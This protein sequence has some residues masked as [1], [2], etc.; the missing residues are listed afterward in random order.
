MRE[1]SARRSLIAYVAAFLT[2]L[3]IGPRAFAAQNEC[4]LSF[5]G[6]PDAATNG[7]AVTCDDCNAACDTDG[8]N[9]PNKSCTF[10]IAVCANE[11]GNGCTAADIKK[12]MV[13]KSGG[14]CKVKGL[15]PT[16][17]GT[18]SVCGAFTAIVVKEK[19]NGKKPGKCKITISAKSKSKPHQQDKDVL[20]LTCT[21]QTASSC[22]TTTSTTTVSSTTTTTMAVC[23]DGIKNGTEQCDDGN[24]VED[25]GCDSNCTIPA[26]GNGILDAS[27]GEACDPPCGAGCSAGQICNSQCQCVAAAACACGTQDP[28]TL[29]FT[30]MVGSGNCG[31]IQDSTGTDL[32]PIACGGLYFGGGGDAVPLPAIVPDMGVSITKTCCN[33]SELTLAATTPADTGSPRNCSGKDCLFGAPLP[34]PNTAP[35]GAPVSTCVINVVAQ[36]AVGTMSCTDGSS[37]LSLPLTSEVYLFGDLLRGGAPDQP[38]I[39]G[40]QP[41]PICNRVCTGGTGDCYTSPFGPG[42]PCAGDTDCSSG[43][44]AAEPTCLGGPNHGM[45]CMP[46]T[47]KTSVCEDGTKKDKPCTS[48]GDCDGSKCSTLRSPYPTTHDCPVPNVMPVGSLPIPF[49]LTTGTSSDTAKASGSEQRVFCGFCRDVDDTFCFEGDP[50]TGCPSSSA[51]HPCESDSDCAQPFEACEQK[52][53]GAFAFPT[54]TTLS[55]TGTPAGAIATGNPPQASTLVSVFCIPPTFNPSIDGVADLPGPG[56]VALPGTAQLKP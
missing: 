51:L 42:C 10:N 45:M 48:V 7:G 4:L 49:A 9:T 18:S 25:D 5:K 13:K 3:V 36:N 55:A 54:A 30:T 21:P 11:P 17:N 37:S 24:Q 14:S 28:A 35:Q 23:G 46:A 15:K 33:G 44:C 40:I 56:A 1:G 47:T 20:T 31:T 43:T 22:P 34:I 53:Q 6:V 52:T 19:K 26:C 38:D 41:C 12:V 39:P 32:K 2:L 50:G 29:N 8:M 27:L 16:P